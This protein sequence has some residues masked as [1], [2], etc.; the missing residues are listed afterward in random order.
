MSTAHV[1][2]SVTKAFVST[3]AS[4]ARLA[5]LLALNLEGQPHCCEFRSATCGKS[6]RYEETRQIGPPVPR[7]NS[8]GETPTQRFH[9]RNVDVSRGSP[10][11]TSLTGPYPCQ[12]S[13]GC[14]KGRC[15]RHTASERHDVVLRAKRELRLRTVQPGDV[16]VQLHRGRIPTGT[17]KGKPITSCESECPGFQKHDMHVDEV[18]EPTAPK[19][20]TMSPMCL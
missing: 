5:T 2:N 15:L 20:G 14:P 13:Q 6:P 9:F 12:P 8:A 3:K 7:G 1:L 18:Y 17:K 19:V 11:D 16:E 4:R 10:V